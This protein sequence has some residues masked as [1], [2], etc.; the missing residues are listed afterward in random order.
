M[1]APQTLLSEAE[2]LTRLRDYLTHHPIPGILLEPVPEGVRRDDN[3]Y[4]VPILLKAGEPAA[5]QYYDLLIDIEE[6]FRQQE[7]LNV[8][9]VPAN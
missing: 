2:V 9:L 3:W 6:Q 1:I 7:H 8:L 4:Y 5:Y